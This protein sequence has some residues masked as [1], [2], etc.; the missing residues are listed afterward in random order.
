MSEIGDSKTQV[1]LDQK[2]LEALTIIQKNCDWP[3]SLNVLS[4]FAIANGLGA[5]RWAFNPPK[6]K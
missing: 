6:K 3:V 2:S 4:N 1:R 5:T